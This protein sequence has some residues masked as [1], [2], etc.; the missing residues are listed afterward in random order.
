MG[1]KTKSLRKSLRKPTPVWFI[2]SG[3]LLVSLP[4]F[5]GLPCFIESAYFVAFAAAVMFIFVMLGVFYMSD[6]TVYGRYMSRLYIDDGFR[7][8][9]I[10]MDGFMK[11]LGL[12]FGYR[13]GRM[14]VE[15]D[16]GNFMFAQD[17]N[18]FCK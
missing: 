13:M 6:M 8:R 12:R 7:D 15:D 5:S 2:L 1:K 17:I 14:T 16:E 4:V 11:E 9:V 10:R 3:I 18:A